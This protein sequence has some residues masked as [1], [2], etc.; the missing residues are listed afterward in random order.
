MAALDEAVSDADRETA[1]LI[2]AI[3]ASTPGMHDFYGQ[4]A[5]YLGGVSRESFNL[6]LDAWAASATFDLGGPRDAEAEAKI[7]SGWVP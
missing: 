7:R 1:A 2:C 4:V 5:A 6:A 3:A